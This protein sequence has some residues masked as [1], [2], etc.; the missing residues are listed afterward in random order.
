MNQQ[1]GWAGLDEQERKTALSQD[2]NDYPECVRCGGPLIDDPKEC[3][4]CGSPQD[5]ENPTE[6]TSD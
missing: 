3:K 2:P 6:R 1:R 5:E 4:S